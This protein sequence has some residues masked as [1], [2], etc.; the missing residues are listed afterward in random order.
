[1]SDTTDTNPVAALFVRPDSIY[2]TLPGV[3]CYDIDRDARTFPGGMP[4]VAHPPCRTW[5][6]L[7]HLAKAPEHEHDLAIW[8]IRAV[9]ENG[10]VLEH[11]RNSGLWRERHLSPP[12]Q[13]KLTDEY[14][15]WTY[16]CDQFHWGHLAQ[17]RTR[18]Y[19]VGTKDLPP[20]PHRPG[21]PTHCVSS[22][23]GKRIGRDER[24]KLKTWK[25]EL[26]PNRRDKTPPAFAMWLVTLA[27]GCGAFRPMRADTNSERPGD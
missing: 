17:K 8:A 21:K 11:P 7:A 25:P 14:G 4:V 13:L 16:E 5:G 22:L 26:G 15:G 10:G 9:R 6:T 27:R 3:E 20:V 24:R 19:I 18:L 23:S 2:K 12:T 1:M